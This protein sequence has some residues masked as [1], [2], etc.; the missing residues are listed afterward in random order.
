MAATFRFRTQHTPVHVPAPTGGAWADDYDR[1]GD[2]DLL[3]RLATTGGLGWVESLGDGTFEPWRALPDTAGGGMIL[4]DGDGDG[5]LDRAEVAADGALVLRRGDTDG[6]FGPALVID[7]DPHAPQL[8]A[9]DF[10]ADGQSEVGGVLADGATVRILRREGEGP[11][12]RWSE[13]TLGPG[14][15]DVSAGDLDGDGRPEVAVVRRGADLLHV[16]V[17][18]GEPGSL[19]LRLPV[20]G[21]VFGV[22]IA[23]FD[24]DGL[25]DVVTSHVY[26]GGY[27]TGGLAFRYGTGQGDLSE[28]V[29]MT[30]SIYEGWM[31][32][33]DLER[34]GAA[35]VFLTG[36]GMYRHVG[37]ARPPVRVTFPDHN[38]PRQAAFGD[39]DG[40]TRIDLFL[41]SA[42][43]G[44]GAPET[45]FFSGYQVRFYPGDGP[46]FPRALDGYEFIPRPP[47]AFFINADVAD[48]DV[49]GRD[50]VLVEFGDSLVVVRSAGRGNPS[51]ARAFGFPWNEWAY[52]IVTGDLNGDGFPD[53]AATASFRREG[54]TALGDGQG[55]FG[56]WRPFAVRSPFARIA[57]ADLDGDARPDLAIGGSVPGEPES[58]RVLRGAGDGTFLPWHALALAHPLRDLASA[59]TG[60][61]SDRVALL[62]QSEANWPDTRAQLQILSPVAG[63]TPRL[64]NAH[65]FRATA[66]AVASRRVAGAADPEWVVFGLPFPNIYPTWVFPGWLVRTTLDAS[67]TTDSVDAGE[68]L[69]VPPAI[70]DLDADGIED[71]AYSAAHAEFDLLRGIPGPLDPTPTRIGAE[72]F[73]RP[74][75]GDFDGDRRIDL[76]SVGRLG[77]SIL[78]NDGAVPAPPP[79]IDLRAALLRDQA[80]P[81][82]RG[83]V[84]ATIRLAG[85]ALANVDPASLRLAGHAPT[86]WSPIHA[87]AEGCG[88]KADR[89]RGDA[90]EGTR[91]RDFRF[92]DLPAEVLRNGLH[93]ELRDLGG[94]AH[95]LAVCGIDPVAG[96]HA[97]TASRTPAATLA[98]TGAE[99]AILLELAHPS[100]NTSIEVFD[101]RGRRVGSLD[102]GSLEVGA[103]RIALG[104]ATGTARLRPGLYFVRV[105][106]DGFEQRLR[107]VRLGTP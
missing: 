93:L 22:R 16:Y 41:G 74:M 8:V 98:G 47:E 82:A 66:H 57:L 89:G 63:S 30:L 26:G 97:P 10:D 37:G 15:V 12:V 5:T 64:S 100:A 102:A 71:I 77:Y 51:E 27:T 85:T 43:R 19:D 58:L 44:V 3:V 83:T 65:S 52:D 50:D 54:A 68:L 73:S 60:N 107:W 59:R 96:P 92:D 35:E 34:D 14:I 78:W 86:R 40:D 18:L 79:P 95:E 20:N 23:D 25:G 2:D 48:V 103:H 81:V 94:V 29:N 55:G 104:P 31:S 53:V 88:D 28:P 56:A 17:P 32:V 13:I 61:G 36:T 33:G 72:R 45:R 21:Q 80:Q 90:A 46:G 70:A 101:V 99:P 11:W 6:T 38:G 4:V 106:A 84:R 67:V 87:G 105:R 24:G 75:A 91:I 42:S 39:F 69:L 62:L 7:A 49:D 1:D 76:L 9:A